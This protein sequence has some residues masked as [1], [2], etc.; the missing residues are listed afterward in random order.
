[1]EC[2][3]TVKDPALFVDVTGH[4][5]KVTKDKLITEMFEA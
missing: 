5:G 2:G 1:M 4:T 3:V